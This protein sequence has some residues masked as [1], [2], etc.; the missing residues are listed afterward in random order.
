MTSLAEAGQAIR[1]AKSEAP[2][3]P[4]IVMVTVDE[5]GSCLDGSSAETAARRL[6]EWGADA[7]G[8]NCSAGP[9][10]VLS[11]IERMR[12]TT[13]LPLAAMPNARMPKGGR[14]EKYLSGLAGVYVKFRAEVC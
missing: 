10:T 6:T 8:C 1:A 12:A 4:V 2:E 9:A 7:V 13:T 3:V 5:E 11:V 14:W